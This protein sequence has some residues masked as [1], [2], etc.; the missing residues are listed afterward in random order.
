VKDKALAD[1]QKPGRFLR[2]DDGQIIINLKPGP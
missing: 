2:Y 1:R